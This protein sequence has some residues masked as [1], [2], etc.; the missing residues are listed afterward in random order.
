MASF[1]GINKRRLHGS[2]IPA[3]QKRIKICVAHASLSTHV[4]ADPQLTLT[5]PATLTAWTG[6]DALTHALEALM[7]D[8]HHPMCDGIALESL[9]IIHRWLPVAVADGTNLEARSRMLCASAMAAVAFQK[10]LGATQMG[11]AGRVSWPDR[12]ASSR[13]CSGRCQVRRT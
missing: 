11:C 7:V 4:V 8:M 2:A 6:M 9:R 10:G 3:S 1:G 5:L 12:P 13:P